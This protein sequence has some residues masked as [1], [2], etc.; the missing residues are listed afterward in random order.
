[1]DK[2]S[3]LA[4]VSGLFSGFIRCKIAYILPAE[5]VISVLNSVISRLFFDPPFW[6]SEILAIN[7]T[8]IQNQ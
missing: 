4:R 8:Y 5:S 2:N 3:I 6:E 1:L 7:I